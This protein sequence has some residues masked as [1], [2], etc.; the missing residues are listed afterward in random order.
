MLCGSFIF[1]YFPQIF[2]EFMDVPPDILLLKGH[3]LIKLGDIGGAKVSNS[4]SLI[5]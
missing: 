2:Q 5:L 3:V 4:K 1:V